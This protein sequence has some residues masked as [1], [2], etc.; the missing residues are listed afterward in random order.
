MLNLA[1]PYILSKISKDIICEILQNNEG[2][3]ISKLY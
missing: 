3:E 2:L 1:D